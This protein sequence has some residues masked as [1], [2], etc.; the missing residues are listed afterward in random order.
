MKQQTFKS[1]G[2][3]VNFNVPGT[4]E[5]FD[6]N[7]KAVGSCLAQAINNIVYR[8]C[9]AEFRDLFLYGRDEDKDETTGVVTPSFKGVQQISGINPL[10]K[11]VTKGE[12]KTTVFTESEGDYFDRVCAEQVKAGK[13]PDLSSAV[14]S[15]Q[16]LADAT[17]ALIVFDA[18]ATVRKAPK[19][20]KLSQQFVDLAKAIYSGKNLQ[21]F[22]STASKLLGR[23][24]ALSGATDDE[25]VTSLGWI[26][27]EYDAVESKKQE[28]A[29]LKKIQDLAA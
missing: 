11:E 8:G 29:R 2:L 22:L 7:A 4:V 20:K 5:E 3:N 6:T 19:A 17:T 13:F 21:K 15:Y 16:S 14:A 24:V 18:S 27:K 9:L 10:T 23:T 25:K 1:L 26:C 28:E 12:T